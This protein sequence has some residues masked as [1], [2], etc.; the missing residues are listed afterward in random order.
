M[1]I[2]K[3]QFTMSKEAMV[4]TP[5]GNITIGKVSDYI[6][7]NGSVT[8]SVA[9]KEGLPQDLVDNLVKMPQGISIVGKVSVPTDIQVIETDT[10]S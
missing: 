9:L 2:L 8:V 6:D 3:F 7:N 10:Q 1:K 4:K 5:V